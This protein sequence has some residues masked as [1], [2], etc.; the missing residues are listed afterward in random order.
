MA[1]QE[2]QEKQHRI[3]EFYS[4]IGGMHYAFNLSGHQGQVL[5]AFDINTTANEVYAHNHG[6]KQLAQY[7]RTGNQEGSKDTRAKSFL[8]L[9]RI[10]PEMEHP[11]SYLLLENV[12]GFEESD[13]RDLLVETLAKCGYEYQEL[14]ITPLQIGIP[15]SRMRYYCVA[16]KT[17]KVGSFQHPVTGTLIG[18]IPTPEKDGS[19]QDGFVDTRRQGELSGL[20]TSAA[21][22]AA[23]E[24]STAT[25]TTTTTAST[26]TAEKHPA[27]PMPDTEEDAEKS[28]TTKKR[29]TSLD[30]QIPVSTTTA[31]RQQAHKPDEDDILQDPVRAS[32]VEPLAGYIEFLDQDDARMARY[33]ISDSTLLKYG[34]LF[35]IVK[36]S[37]RRSCCFTKG[38]HHFVESTGSILQM[39]EDKDTAA[40]YD[41]AMALKGTSEEGD[42]KALALLRSL[43]LRYFTENEIAHLMGFPIKDG[44]FSFPE[45]TTLK[46]RY[47]VLGNSINVKV[48]S[49]LIRYL[50]A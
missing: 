39:V 25:N 29:R 20:S 34:R 4:G 40:V 38:Y 30:T 2:S 45:K 15:N 33:M 16:R 47:R 9:M 12:K 44:R 46:Q 21:T 27:S 14:L 3:L 32:Q 8:Y 11:P 50:L 26:A 49:Q 36:P 22:R 41:E 48:V 17:D 23:A 10:L 35:D 6:K 24:A 18:Y 7:T 42:A 19:S 31:G 1:K 5:K 43:Q 13:S 37:M 28:T